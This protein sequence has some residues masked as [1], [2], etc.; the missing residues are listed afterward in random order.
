MGHG[1][2]RRGPAFGRRDHRLEAERLEAERLEFA[3]LLVKYVD[4]VADLRQ[5]PGNG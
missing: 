3:R 1:L 5:P 2:P 4:A